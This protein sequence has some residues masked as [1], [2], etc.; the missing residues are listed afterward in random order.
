MGKTY[1]IRIGCNEEKDPEAEKYM[2]ECLEKFLHNS[3]VIV[4]EA[5]NYDSYLEKYKLTDF[6]KL[7]AVPLPD[8]IRIVSDEVDNFN[9]ILMNSYTNNVIDEIKE[10]H[11]RYVGALCRSICRMVLKDMHLKQYE[12]SIGVT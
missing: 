5:S 8:V 1:T 9:M 4:E 2:L 10:E 7:F 11:H 12:V 6:A 3:W